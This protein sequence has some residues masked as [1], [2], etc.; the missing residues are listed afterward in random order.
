MQKSC[1]VLCQVHT[2]KKKPNKTEGNEFS[3]NSM[4]N[5]GWCQTL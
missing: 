5:C 4:A 1:T 3:S 2:V